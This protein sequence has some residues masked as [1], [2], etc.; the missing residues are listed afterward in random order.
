[1]AFRWFFDQTLLIKVAISWGSCTHTFWSNTEF[2]K[3]PCLGAHSWP[4][5]CGC[6]AKTAVATC[7]NGFKHPRSAEKLI[8]LR[9]GRV[10]CRST[11]YTV[12]MPY[13]YFGLWNKLKPWEWALLWKKIKQL[14]TLEADFSAPMIF[15]PTVCHWGGAGMSVRSWD[16]IHLLQRSHRLS[17]QG[18]GEQEGALKWN[19]GRGWGWTTW[20]R[21]GWALGQKDMWHKDCPAAWSKEKYPL[22]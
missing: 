20:A 15:H 4:H 16:P 22:S 10:R 19:T 14:S 11:T 1:M 17:S 21:S 5:L 3:N 7:G 13:C 9:A 18:P 12:S 6:W 8:G 2:G